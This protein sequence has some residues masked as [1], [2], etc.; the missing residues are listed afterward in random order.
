MIAGVLVELV[1]KTGAVAPEQMGA[2]AANVGIINA[3]V[4]MFK[5]VGTAHNPAVGVNV[6]VAVPAVAVLTTGDHVPVIAGVFVELVGKTGAVEFKQTSDIAE[7]VGVISGFTV[8]DN[9]AVIA[10]CPAVGVNV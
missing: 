7:K 1:G 2:I 9:V 6:Y 3:V 8:I 10:H 5:V 4:T